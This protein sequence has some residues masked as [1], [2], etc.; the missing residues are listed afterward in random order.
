MVKD[1]YDPDKDY[2][3]HSRAEYLI[4]KHGSIEN[5]PKL[6]KEGEKVKS[7]EKAVEILKGSHPDLINFGNGKEFERI[8]KK[9]AKTGYIIKNSYDIPIKDF[10]IIDGP[11]KREMYLSLKKELGLL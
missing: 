7:L 6:I 8:L 2:G 9:I 3:G 11:K 4:R 1:E 5:A 10:S